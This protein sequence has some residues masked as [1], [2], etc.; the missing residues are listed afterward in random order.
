MD[1]LLLELEELGFPM[2][3]DWIHQGGIDYNQALKHLSE[4]QHMMEDEEDE[5][6][7]KRATQILNEIFNNN[8]NNK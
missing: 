3:A 1:K 6:A 5:K 4:N 2:L 8:Q 7:F